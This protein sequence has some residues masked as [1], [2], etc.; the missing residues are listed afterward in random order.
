[1]TEV[2]ADTV[3]YLVRYNFFL[4]YFNLIHFC[5]LFFSMALCNFTH[6][7]N[8]YSNNNHDGGKEIQEYDVRTRINH[9]EVPTEIKLGRG[10]LVF[11]LI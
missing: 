8:K 4:I 9:S 6:I 7:T 2:E 11:Y 10:F 3:I 5:I 1:M